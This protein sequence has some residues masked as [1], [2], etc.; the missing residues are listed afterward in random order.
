MLILIIIKS[1]DTLNIS[2]VKSILVEDDEHWSWL[3]VDL[4]LECLFYIFTD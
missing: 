4:F 3:Y 2:W 1:F